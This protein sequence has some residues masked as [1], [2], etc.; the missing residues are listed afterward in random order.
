VSGTQGTKQFFAESS[1][2]L[3]QG[4]QRNVSLTALDIPNVSKSWNLDIDGDG[5]IGDLSDGIIAVRYLFGS[6]FSGNVLID[7]AIA[8]DA[9]RNLAG[10]QS[11]LSGLTNLL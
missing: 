1:G 9:T 5:N 10:V 4:E 6:A 2:F 11:Y 8:P 3:A 7:K